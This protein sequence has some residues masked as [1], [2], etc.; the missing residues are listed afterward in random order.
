MSGIMI[1]HEYSWI[2]WIRTKMR[3]SWQGLILIGRRRTNFVSIQLL[4]THSHVL[5][6]KQ[7]L[8]IQLLGYLKTFKL[9]GQFWLVNFNKSGEIWIKKL[10]NGRLKLVK[11]S[12]WMSN[13][14]VDIQ[15][16]PFLFQKASYRLLDMYIWEYIDIWRAVFRLISNVPNQS[17]FHA[18][19]LLLS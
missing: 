11:T 14:L 19:L 18:F 15:I 13:N 3:K 5:I 10:K 12:F 17:M 6:S 4:N 9:I 8:H 16:N 2:S 7:D 1:F